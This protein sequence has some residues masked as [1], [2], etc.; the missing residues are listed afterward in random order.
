MITATRIQCTGGIKMTKERRLA[1]E[2]WEKIVGELEKKNEAESTCY[3]ICDTKRDF[4][5][6]NNLH[7]ENDC[8]FCQYVRHDYR[9]MK[10]RKHIPQTYNG[11]QRCPLYKEEADTHGNDD[12]GCDCGQRNNTLWKRVVLD[13][14]TSAAKR[15]LEL[16]KGGHGEPQ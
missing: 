16:L 12:C 14:D 8:W 6:S 11:C 4:C 13:D 7:W 2:M 10:S 15:I 5:L 1:I 9:P 3:I